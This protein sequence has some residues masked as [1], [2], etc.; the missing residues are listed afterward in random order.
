M[1]GEWLASILCIRN[2]EAPCVVVCTQSAVATF[3]SAHLII[4]IW[5]PREA[6]NLQGCKSSAPVTGQSGQTRTHRKGVANFASLQ[7][8]FHRQLFPL[9]ESL[10]Q[11]LVHT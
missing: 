10:T 7:Q 6:D 4:T 11:T 9:V 8:Q 1:Q 3:V 2:Q 5:Q